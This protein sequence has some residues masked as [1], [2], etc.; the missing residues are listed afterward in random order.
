MRMRHSYALC[1]RPRFCCSGRRAVMEADPPAGAAAEAAPRGRP[2]EPPVGAAARRA[3]AVVRRCGAAGA[4]AARPGRPAA[5]PGRRAAQ[6]GRPAVQ[7][8]AAVAAVARV[9]LVAQRAGRPAARLGRRAVARQA[10]LVVQRARR[11]AQRVRPAVQPVRPGAARRALAA[12]AAPPLPALTGTATRPLLTTAGAGD[13]TIAKYFDKAGS[14]TTG[15]TTDS[16]NPIAGVGDVVE[17]SR[18]RTPSPRRAARTPPCKR[19]SRTRSP[20]AAPTA[21]S[22]A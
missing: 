16:L 20:R 22:S 11:A 1:L 15:L 21:S 4:A 7:R 12:R 6:P 8:D 5:R 13:Y 3:R 18:P 2:A 10:R 9:R 14:L 17:R 19:R